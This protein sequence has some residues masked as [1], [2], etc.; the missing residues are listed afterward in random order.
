MEILRH[1]EWTPSRLASVEYGSIFAYGSLQ[2]GFKEIYK[3]IACVPIFNTGNLVG[4]TA[5]KGDVED[6]AV[7]YQDPHL[8]SM[9]WYFD[10]IAVE[11]NKLH[12]L[13]QVQQLLK[14][15]DAMLKLY[16]L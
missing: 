4:W 2:D 7:Y 6:F 13:D 8:G 1:S 11:G 9:E 14:C 16:R 5:V 10:R 12:N 15:D 3:G